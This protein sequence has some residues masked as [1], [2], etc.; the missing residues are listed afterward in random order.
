M[1]LSNRRMADL[2]VIVV[3]LLALNSR[4]VTATQTVPKPGAVIPP[5]KGSQGAGNVTPYE[6]ECCTD[7]GAIE[8]C[9]WQDADRDQVTCSAINPCPGGRPC[10]NNP[11]AG[12]DVKTGTEGLPNPVGLC[13]CTEDSH[14]TEGGMQGICDE[15]RGV[16]GPSWCNG[17][18]RCSCWGG[19]EEGK[20]AGELV[21]SDGCA[22]NATAV[23]C[24]E[25]EY[26]KLPGTDQIGYCS[27]W[28]SCVDPG[29]GGDAGTSAGSCTAATVAADCTAY[30]GN[31]CM[32]ATCTASDECRYDP[33]NAGTCYDKSDLPGTLTVVTAPFDPTD[34]VCCC[35]TAADCPTQPCIAGVSCDLDF[36][37]ADTFQTCGIIQANPGDS[38][39]GP[40]AD[41]PCHWW[42]CNAAA[43]MDCELNERAVDVACSDDL[44]LPPRSNTDC[45]AWTC[46]GADTFRDC[47]F[48]TDVLLKQSCDT[49]PPPADQCARRFCDA[50]GSCNLSKSAGETCGPIG[51]PNYLDLY[52][53]GYTCDASEACSPNVP[54]P[55]VHSTPERENCNYEASDD[56]G[57]VSAGDRTVSEDLTCADD[58]VNMAGTASNPRFSSCDVFDISDFVY[59]YS[60]QTNQ[61][62]FGLRHVLAYVSDTGALNWDPL[63]Y[64]TTACDG[65]PASQYT[66]NDDCNFSGTN[67]NDYSCGV[68]PLADADSAAVTAGPW[69]IVDE[70]VYSG[71]GVTNDWDSNGI[72]DG[73]VLDSSFEGWL[74]VDSPQPTPPYPPGGAFDLTA[75]YNE[76]NNNS[77]WNTASYMATPQIT[78]E[79]VWKERWRGSLNGYE[80]FVCKTAGPNPNIQD[81]F[82][83]GTPDCI[84]DDKSIQLTSGCWTGT[85]AEVSETDPGQAFYRV[86]LPEGL[87]KIYTDEAGMM[88]SAAGW[89]DPTDKTAP[90]RGIPY[91]D[92]DFMSTVL[93]TWGGGTSSDG[94][95]VGAINPDSPSNVCEGGA[96]GYPRE[97]LFDNDATGWHGW[98]EVSNN[99]PGIKGDYELNV[100][101][102]PQE[103]LGMMHVYH[104]YDSSGGGCACGSFSPTGDWPM[105][106]DRLDFVP[107][108]DPIAGYSVSNNNVST[109]PGYWVVDPDI[110]DTMGAL[111]REEACV[112][113]SGAQSCTRTMGPY[114]FPFKFPYSGELWGYY[115]INGAGAV[116]LRRSPT[117]SCPAWDRDPSS[118]KI[119]GQYDAPDARTSGHGPSILPLWGEIVPC[120]R[121]NR[122]P[123]NI[124]GWSTYT[125]V[126]CRTGYEGRIVRQTIPFE[127]T[128][129]EVITWDGFDGTI[130][131]HTS[132]PRNRKLQ[133]QVIIRIDGRISFFY[134]QPNPTSAW[135]D[136]L[137]TNGWAIGLHGTRSNYCG[138]DYTTSPACTVDADCGIDG[139]YCNGGTCSRTVGNQNL[140]CDT[141]LGGS[142]LLCD[143]A[144]ETVGGTT[145][146]EARYFCMNR[147][148]NAFEIGIAGP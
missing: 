87:Y 103:F 35:D 65:A 72:D 31:P 8:V 84:D 16:C 20:Y 132:G 69:P 99:M 19:C 133:F 80:N 112:G 4:E 145:I 108:D 97:R 74:V 54:L 131:P 113:A 70:P 76:H 71:G 82:P 121:S 110:D 30:A 100:I 128:T 29:P 61:N 23:N 143:N 46:M 141:V 28:V 89:L 5:L 123:T 27:N 111:A 58:D 1:N 142:G 129:A 78:G 48:Q 59:Y 93:A 67:F 42:T 43:A 57:D 116:T 17:F 147:V 11:G 34:T 125:W 73:F 53:Y 63:L 140:H 94:P 45:A 24:C 146:Y 3:A 104:G 88:W 7:P 60:G 56:L 115:C 68:G 92:A 39:T 126:S 33:V 32:E 21:P 22:N 9:W 36:N 109:G 91:Q 25:G 144:N 101:K 13:A 81:V 41:N 114:E 136:I 15:N 79:Q 2:A 66:C 90:A 139:Y 14:C 130:E 122:T 124:S 77:C 102:V 75:E 40:D 10:R 26:P 118:K 134:K 62:E 96:R 49:A 83:V 106:G 135:D 12:D 37:N 119:S 44:A 52:C 6:D 50:A 138:G 18:K 55:F 86:D 95:C 117:D 51:V 64:A 107:T 137:D 148:F 47:I 120:W 85:D 38:C 98:L 127:G 105:P